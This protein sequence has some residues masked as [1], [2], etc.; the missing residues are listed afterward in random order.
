MGMAM[1]MVT[2]TAMAMM[3]AMIDY[4]LLLESNGMIAANIYFSFYIQWKCKEQQREWSKGGKQWVIFCNGYGDGN[5]NGNGNNS[6]DRLLFV[7]W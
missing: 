1:A 5:G 6:N 4:G 2:I 3:T 7:S